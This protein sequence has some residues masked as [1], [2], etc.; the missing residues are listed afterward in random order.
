MNRWT[1]LDPPSLS[2]LQAPRGAQAPEWSV[3][4]PSSSSSPPSAAEC[5]G[6]ASFAVWNPSECLATDAK[7]KEAFGTCLGECTLPRPP[8]F[9]P[10]I[11]LFD[12]PK[13]SNIK[14]GGVSVSVGG[15]VELGAWGSGGPRTWRGGW[16]GGGSRPRQELWGFVCGGGGQ[17]RWPRLGF[18]VL[19]GLL[20]GAPGSLAGRWER[21]P[22]GW[23]WVEGL[24]GVCSGSCCCCRLDVVGPVRPGAGQ[25]QAWPCQLP[26]L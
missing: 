2:P 23:G 7:P 22:W 1:F 26:L 19:E 11:K 20:S 3:S 17:R 5:G 25:S 8:S 16:P 14:P 18:T 15:G 12:G 4:V 24:R 6:G 21:N 9:A 10:C 13:Y